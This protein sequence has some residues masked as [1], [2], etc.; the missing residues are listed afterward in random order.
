MILP[1]IL[2]LIDALERPG[3]TE[4]HLFELSRR[5]APMGYQPIVCNLSG[6]EPVLARIAAEGVETWPERIGRLYLPPGRGVARNVVRRAA[7]RNI[8]AVHTFHFK[9]D[10]MGVSAARSLGC[11]LISSRRDLGFQQNSIRRVIYRW[12]NRRTDAFVAPSEA[13]KASVLKQGGARSSDVHLIYNGLEM[14]R[15]AD[16]SGR[17]ETRAALGIPSDARLIGMVGNLRPVKGHPTLLR[18]V[19]RL[20]NSCPQAHVVLFGDGLEEERLR[21]LAGSLGI[22]AHVTFAGSGHDI[23]TALAALDVFALSSNSEG[24][25]NAVIEAMAAGLPVVATSVGGNPE[26]VVDGETG[27]LTPAGDDERL[28]DRIGRL[29][30]DPALAHTMGEAGRARCRALFDVDTMV[31]RTVELY[32]TLG[33]R[34]REEM[35]GAGK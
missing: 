21:E 27:F 25:S 6:S 22:G 9:S 24:L 5:L 20:M 28:A 34:S 17:D 19:A 1:A 8:R 32:D 16:R 26:C 18:A 13:V 12:I 4:T 14:Q 30:M 10:W 23:P 31:R 11:P 33:C 2:F 3:G 7:G 29:L 15:F 35:A